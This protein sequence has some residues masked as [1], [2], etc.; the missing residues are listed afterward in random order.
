MP[1]YIILLFY[2]KNIFE[3]GEMLK[4]SN[5]ELPYYCIP[6]SRQNLLPVLF[7]T[8]KLAF[9]QSNSNSIKLWLRQHLAA[10]HRGRPDQHRP[11]HLRKEKE[12]EKEESVVK[13]GKKKGPSASVKDS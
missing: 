3:P 1:S 12:K 9:V 11:R 8:F 2:D 13:K 5:Y 6:V 4:S 7:D 10:H